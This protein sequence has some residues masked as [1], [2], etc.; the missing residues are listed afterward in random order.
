MALFSV[1]SRRPW[2]GWL[3]VVGIFGGMVGAGGLLGAWSVICRDGRCPSIASL[4]QYVP[5]QTSKVYAAD[6]RFITELGLER[7]TLVR[8]Q[9]IPKHVRDAVVI[10]EDRRFYSHSGIDYYRV[11]GALARNVKAGRYAQGFST[12]TMWLAPSNSATPKTRSSSST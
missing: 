6:G 10:T 7:R 2:L 1:L 11:F 5:R 12:I 4:E 8:L 9:D 3:L